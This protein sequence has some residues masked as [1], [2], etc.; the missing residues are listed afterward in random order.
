MT[1]ENIECM[2]LINDVNSNRVTEIAE[3]IRENGFTGCPILVMNGQLLT[4]SHR[5]AALRQLAEE[6][7]D[8]DGLGDVAEDVTE[9]A[10]ENMRKYE[11][12]NGWCPDIDYS[13]IGWMLAGSWVEKYKEEIN[14][15]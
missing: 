12:E 10:A 2:A 11:E 5:L 7:F 1:Y 6:G 8:V 3:S 13:N 4:G 9:I 15:W 14:E